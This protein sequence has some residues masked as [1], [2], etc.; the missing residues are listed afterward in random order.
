ML[1]VLLAL[2]AAPPDS[3]LVIAHRG[4]SGERPEHT[5]EAYRLAVEQGADVIEP[6]LVATKDGVLVARHEN[7]ISGTTDVAR[8]PEFA[9]RRTTKTIDGE[10]VTGWFTED[11]TLAEIRT[12]RAVERLPDLRPASA[13][14][15]GQFG[16]PTLDEVIALAQVLG[17]KRGRPV[18]LYPETKHPSYFRA[19]GLPL[20]EPLVE[21]LH[22]AGLTS[23]DDPVWIQSFE[24]GNLER[25]DAMTGLRLVQLAYPGGAP[26][27]RPALGY[28][29]MMTPDGL[30]G[31]AEYADA[32]GVAKAFVLDGD[33]APTPLVADAHAHG[34]AV[35]VWTVRAE[36][37]FLPPALRSSD[38]PGSRG[39]V[40]AEVRALAA[41]GVDGLFTDHPALVLAALGRGGV[42]R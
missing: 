7:E 28:D 3:L 34:L 26:A 1:A 10:A 38:D 4:A 8:R 32:V 9:D 30:G 24:V 33:L 27:D 11:F 41:A 17:A 2:M 15:D 35:H 18:G 39:D 13:A 12:L 14:Y 22:A 16:V 36:N 6:D 19:T 29:A 23:P 31:V 37:A 21:A 5:L 40:A 25:L 20:E 42:T